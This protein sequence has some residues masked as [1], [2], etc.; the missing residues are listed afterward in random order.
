M[1]FK[2]YWHASGMNFD[3]S[4]EAFIR[5]A[6]YASNNK[7]LKKHEARLNKIF[8]ENINKYMSLSGVE[9]DNFS[10][11]FSL[12]ISSNGNINFVN[13]EPLVTQRYEY[14]YYEGSND[15]NEEY[16]EEYMIQTSPRY[17]IRPA[18]QE[19][20]QDIKHIILADAK[21]EYNAL[22]QNQDEIL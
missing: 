12:N 11:V 9:A 21:R 14:G 17:Y 5:S 4:A 22:K 10:E 15:T 3:S 7:N 20:L 8:K 18:I 1:N 19:T 13:T 16:Y 6:Q 2:T